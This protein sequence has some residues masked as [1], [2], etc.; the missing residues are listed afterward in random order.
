MTAD[1]DDRLYGAIFDASPEPVMV[2]DPETGRVLDANPA[3]CALVGLDRE[4]LLGTDIGDVS[5]AATATEG[6]MSAL[7]RAVADGEH[8]T[9][10]ELVG[11]EGQRLSVDVRLKR[12][13]VDGTERVVAFLRDRSDQRAREREHAQWDEQIRTMVDNLPV[14]VFTLDPDGVFTRSAGKGL[15]SLGQEQGEIVGQSLFDVYAGY[16]DIVEAAERAL[17]GEEIRVTQPIDDLVFE[18][19]YQPVFDDGELVQVVGVARNITELKRREERVGALSEATNDL[20][21]THTEAAVAERVCDIAKRIIDRPIAA[22]WSYD[23]DTDVLSPI[24]AT[25]TA[26]DLA[27][28]EIAKDLPEIG[29]GSDEKAIFDAGTPVVIEDYGEL[30]CPAASGLPLGTLLCLPLGDHGLLCVGSTAVEPFEGPD[31]RL[32]EILSSTAI[33]ALDRVARETTLEAQRAQLEASNEALQRR[34]E[35]MEFFN[36][37]LRHDILNGMNVIRAR[38]DLLSQELEGDQRRYAETIVEWS[39]D[40]TELTRKVRSVLHRLADDGAAETKPVKLAPVI[41]SA[42]QRAAS[43][44]AG[45][46]V[47]ISVHSDAVVTADD[48]LHDVFGNILTNAVEHGR[49]G[50]G[51]TVAISVDV[52]VD[53]ETVT[54][55]IADDGPG[56]AQSVREDIFERGKKGSDSGGTGFGLYFVDAMVASYG[57]RIRAQ[58]SDSGGAE[59]V[60]EL[61]R[62]R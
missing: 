39:D 20:L 41:E 49:S 30:A 51:D 34:R 50:D 7:Q 62:V 16:P 1:I 23:A 37:I 33:A 10:W 3:A 15:E 43:M 36:S 32:L 52:T 53:E 4:Q 31:R 24:G 6:A 45:V 11:P 54:V 19:W 60:V 55:R 58:E 2:H 8:C 18:T 5:S 61:P 14:V 48:L 27:G 46:T 59:F 26:T 21:Y 9:E 42:A 56:I 35:Q 40:I 28:V 47:D 38:G 17:S 57:G 29:P 25:E 44:D 13:S 12:I 22:M